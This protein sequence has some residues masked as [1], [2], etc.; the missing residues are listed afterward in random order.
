MTARRAGWTG[1]NILL[2]QIPNAGKV[3]FIKNGYAIS[4]D[5]VLDS[6]QRTAFVRKANS[7]ES[8]RWM[9]DVLTCV[10]KIKK[11]DFILD[12]IYRFEVEL[13]KR[14]PNNS[15]VRDKIRQQLQVLRDKGFVEFVSR[16]KYRVAPNE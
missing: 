2:D 8:R 11:Q 14:H 9:L 7:S 16:G 4:Q 10:E 15:F 13:S 5:K 1:C 3:H 6:W 12:D